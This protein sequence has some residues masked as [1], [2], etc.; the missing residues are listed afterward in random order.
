MFGANRAPVFNQ[1]F[2]YLEMNQNELS[3]E[4]RHLGVPSGPFKMISEAMVCLVQTMRAP[5]LTLS[6]T[7]QNEILH[8]PCHLGVPSSASKIISELTVHSVQTVHLS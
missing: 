2:H 7:D 1:D 3:F 5:I 8:D 4:P 6:R